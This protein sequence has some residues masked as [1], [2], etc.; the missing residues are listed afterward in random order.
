MGGGCS[1]RRSRD[2]PRDVRSVPHAP[3]RPAPSRPSRGCTANRGV[4]G[5]AGWDA[6][7][8]EP[9]NP[10]GLRGRAL[11]VPG[12][13]QTAAATLELGHTTRDSGMT[14]RS[15]GTPP[16]HRQPGPADGAAR[17]WLSTRHSPAPAD[18]AAGSWSRCPIRRRGGP[19]R[20]RTAGHSGT[21]GR[22]SGQLPAHTRGARAGVR[23]VGAGVRA[24]G[25]GLGPHGRG[26]LM[27]RGWAGW[28]WGSVRVVGPSGEDQG[29]CVRHLLCR[30]GEGHGRTV[31]CA[32]GG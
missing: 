12:V 29:A 16:S 9:R 14:G 17:S 30:R 32:G 1:G 2:R 28:A 18:R 27:R 11:T 3:G 26:G 25:P 13:V 23:R 8:S 10:A 21:D 7:W 15:T 22:S 6:V 19:N 20:S 24:D 5:R 31:L 4:R